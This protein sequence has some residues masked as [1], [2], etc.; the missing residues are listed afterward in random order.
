MQINKKFKI[1]IV[2]NMENTNTVKYPSIVL[3][4]IVIGCTHCTPACLAISKNSK[5]QLHQHNYSTVLI[6]TAP[7]RSPKLGIRPGTQPAPE[8]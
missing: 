2:T 8:L 1:L 5:N 4:D 3:D 6:H 7:V